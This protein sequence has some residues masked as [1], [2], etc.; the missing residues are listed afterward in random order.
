[1]TLL[2]SPDYHLL[3]P[4]LKLSLPRETFYQ[5]YY[6]PTARNPLSEPSS[7]LYLTFNASIANMTSRSQA[8]ATVILWGIGR[9]VRLDQ[10]GCQPTLVTNKAGN[11][12]RKN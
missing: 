8:V 9:L 3:P 6:L 7:P 12:V 2:L 1:M 5:P 4:R 10:P 11:T